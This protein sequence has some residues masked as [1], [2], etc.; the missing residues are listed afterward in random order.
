MIA[1][2]Q[3]FAQRKIPRQ[4]HNIQFIHGTEDS[5]PQDTHYQVITTP[6]FLDLFTQE[7]LPTVISKLSKQG[8]GGSEAVGSNAV[9][10]ES[11]I[12]K[13]ANQKSPHQS[14]YLIDFQI[15]KNLFRPIAQGL[16]WMMYRFFRFFTHI[17]A[18]RLL[19]FST[20]LERQ[21]YR[22]EKEK[23]YFAG[24]IISQMWVKS[25]AKAS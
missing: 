21:H 20:Y 25:D 2:A 13:S 19:S 11:V 3:A 12:S 7:E 5:I 22:L 1:Q 9:G 23:T 15:P 17:S 10:S 16:V 18:T 14:W 6:F 4:L 8:I 24:M